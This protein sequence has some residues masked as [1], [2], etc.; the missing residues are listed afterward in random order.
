MKKKKVTSEHLNSAISSIPKLTRWESELNYS[1]SKLN[2]PKLWL[3]LT[4][5]FRVK[6]QFPTEKIETRNK[7]K[8]NRKRRR[9]P[10][11]SLNQKEEKTRPTFLGLF[12]QIELQTLLFLLL[13][14][15]FQQF[16][17]NFLV[18]TFFLEC[19]M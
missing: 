7:R 3:K 1:Q 2:D 16:K 13:E 5:Q 4:G 19:Y 10:A 8:K 15:F 9:R 18:E 6:R 17:M 11:S 12:N 14:V